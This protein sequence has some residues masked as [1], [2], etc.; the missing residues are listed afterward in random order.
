M[1]SIHDH[2]DRMLAR[3]GAVTTVPVVVTAP[4][5]PPPNS[6]KTVG[7][8]L[9]VGLLSLAGVVVVADMRRQ[10]KMTPAERAREAELR[11]ME[12]LSRPR[13]ISAT[14]VGTP[15]GNF[16]TTEYR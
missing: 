1:A 11:R 8:I 13:F 6:D 2:I 5:S 14:S 15:W 7:V 9:A 16:T 12:A 10:A 3:T 4:P